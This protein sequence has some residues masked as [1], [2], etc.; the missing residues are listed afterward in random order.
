MQGA[1]S[2]LPA[3]QGPES[4]RMLR[5]TRRQRQRASSVQEARKARTVQ[6]E[7]PVQGE[8]SG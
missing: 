6:E 4:T 5:R 2:A 7:W 8:L 3:G 1:R